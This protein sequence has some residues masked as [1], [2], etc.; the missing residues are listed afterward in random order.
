M[1]CTSSSRDPSP[2]YIHIKNMKRRG[3]ILSPGNF[4][5]TL[6]ILAA[7]DSA[8][9]I[10]IRAGRRTRIQFSG[11]R[12]Q[13]S[14]VVLLGRGDGKVGESGLGILVFEFDNLHLH[15]IHNT[16]VNVICRTL[17][18]TLGI[19]NFNSQLVSVLASSNILSL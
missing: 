5:C 14:F 4:Y 19:L 12:S 8:L 2:S 9:I 1:G 13:S 11:P 16:Y 10:R 3:Y 17:N 18:N 7:P 15:S 6:D